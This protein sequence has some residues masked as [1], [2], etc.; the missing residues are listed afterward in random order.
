MW[1]VQ[2]AEKNTESNGASENHQPGVLVTPVGRT[3]SPGIGTRGTRILLGAMAHSRSHPPHSTAQQRLCQSHHNQLNYVRLKQLIKE[4]SPI[5]NEGFSFIWAKL[6]PLDYTPIWFE[7]ETMP[8]S[9]ICTGVADEQFN[10]GSYC[11]LIL[12]QQISV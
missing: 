7:I 4:A 8:D 9:P 2:R 5:Y 12:W 1:R 3:P 10:F 6:A 11:N